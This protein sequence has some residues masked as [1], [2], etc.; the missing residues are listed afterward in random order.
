[1]SHVHSTAHRRP[2]WLLLAAAVLVVSCQPRP[3]PADTASTSGSKSDT[4]EVRPTPPPT[5]F[6]TFDSASRTDL[7][8]YARSLT[9]DTLQ[10]MMDAQYLV[11]EHD[12]RLE[13]GPFARLSPEI[14]AA[15]ITGPALDSGRILARFVLDR[16]FP[17]GGL[18]AGTTYVWVDSTARGFRSTFIPADSGVRTSSWALSTR[19]AGSLFD[20]RAHAWFHEHSSALTLEASY[21][22]DKKICTNSTTVD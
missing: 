10:P 20:P 13:V 21:N 17:E 22:C 18:P 8:A 16:A 1:M 2:P 12:G 9:F 4:T 11:L 3:N 15:V 5:T 14:G 19:P 7:L 6:T